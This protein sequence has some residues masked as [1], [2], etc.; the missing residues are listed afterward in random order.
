MMRLAA[1]G[2]L[3]TVLVLAPLHARGG[4]ISVGDLIIE[5]PWALPTTKLD[6]FAIGFV[7][8]INIGANADRLKSATTERSER[9]EIYSVKLTTGRAQRRQLRRGLKL[10][11]RSVTD[12]K[13]GGY[14]LR[15]IG[16]KR[17]LRKG[18]SFNVRFNFE[19][20]GTVDVLFLT[21]SIGGKSPYPDAKQDTGGSA[22]G[23]RSG[24]SQKN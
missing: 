20:A 16:L 7:S 3:C 23:S 18:E 21:S 19:K 11:A 12:L 24:R 15:F 2:A 14:H 17:P 10:A 5:R 13:P 22:S 9:V 4:D 8:L 6:T 1:L